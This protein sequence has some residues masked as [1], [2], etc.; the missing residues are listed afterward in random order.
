MITINKNFKA[1]LNSQ[2]TSQAHPYHLVDQS[3][4]PMFISWTL[5]MMAIGGVLTMQGYSFGNSLLT[6]GLV[7]TC[8]V[9]FLWLGDVNLEG[10]FLGFHT[11]EVKKGI[12]L[13]FILFIV[14]EGFVFLAVFWAFFH[15]ALVPSVEI[16]VQ[17]PPL[18][19][20]PLDPFAIPLLNTFLLVSSGAFITYGHHS[21]IAGS[22][23]ETIVS[24]LIT[25][26]LAIVF[27]LFQGYEYY[28]STFTIADS[29]FGTVFYSSTGLHGFHVLVG[30]IMII[31]GFIRIVIYNI[32]KE[33]HMG[34]ETAI[35][36]W[37]FVDVVWLFLFLSVYYWGCSN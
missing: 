16:G 3:P 10:T 23:K 4:W 17:W 31:F 34:I 35:A 18:G 8:T 5:F 24:F 30:G 15:S 32:T 1:G 12:M 37:H 33:T 20:T 13:G 28:T 25:I 14:S 11:K 19:I 21:L 29:V 27:M 22:R 36:Y 6:I 2:R 7:L 9:M 26:V